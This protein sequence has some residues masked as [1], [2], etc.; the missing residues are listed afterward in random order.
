MGTLTVGTLRLAVFA[1]ALALAAPAAA[2]EREAD[3]TEVRQIVRQALD[4]VLAVLAQQEL[5]EAERLARIET[6]AYGHFDFASMSRLS[7][8]RNW[9]HLAPEQQQQFMEEFKELLARNYGKRL[10][11]YGD[12]TVAI[13]GERVGV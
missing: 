6:I 10:D 4:E 9:K 5:P 8:G 11:R 7:L 3:L 13:V 12:E 2:A 1:F